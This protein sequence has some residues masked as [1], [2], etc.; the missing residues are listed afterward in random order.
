M[1]VSSV[2]VVIAIACSVR[3]AILKL[4]IKQPKP[5]EY[6]LAFKDSV[7]TSA[8]V[9]DKSTKLDQSY[10]SAEKFKEKLTKDQRLD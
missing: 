4:K 6:D 9:H 2:V 8:S 5:N 7:M 10:V 1:T 3:F